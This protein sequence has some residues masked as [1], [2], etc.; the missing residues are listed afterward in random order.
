MSQL[1]E[2]YRQKIVPKLAKEFGLANS[3]AMPRVLKVTLNLGAKQMAKD[4]N[5]ID[6]L[7]EELAAIASQK[8]SLRRAKKSIAGFQLGRGEPIGLSVTLRGKRMYDFLEKLFRI[9]LPRVRDF[10]GISPKGL[11]GHGNLTLGMAEQIV[12]PEIDFSKMEK[13]HGLAVTIVTNARDDGRAR[14][15]LEELGLPFKK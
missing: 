5:L 12:F 10:Q 14:R 3:L 8:P 2:K 4:K 9:V 13:V 7:S 11:D 1:E 15:L 6:K